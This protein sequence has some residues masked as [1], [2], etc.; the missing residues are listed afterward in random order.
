[1]SLLIQKRSLKCAVVLICIASCI[2]VATARAKKTVSYAADRGNTFTL[3][4]PTPFTV[5]KTIAVP[6]TLYSIDTS[7]TGDVVYLA[8]NLPLIISVPHGGMLEPAIPERKGSWGFIN[9][10]DDV[11]TID[12]ACDLVKAIMDRTNGKYPHV[13]INNI[14]R[15]KIDQNRGWGED[16]NP[17]GG[18]GGDAWKDFHERFI[19]SIAIPEVLKQYNTGLFIDLHGKPDKY[20][21]DIIVGYNLTSQD[22]SNSDKKLN[23]SK[24]S[25]ADKSTLR[26]LSKKLAAEIDFAELL[27]GATRNHESFGSLLQAGI[28]DINRNYKKKYSVIPRHEQKHPLVNLSG[29]YNIQVFCGVRHGATDNRYGYTDSRFISGFQ[30]EVCREIRI[31]NP[32]LRVDFA[33]K[34]ADAII[35]YTDRNLN[36]KM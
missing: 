24:R 9:K 20:G 15:T 6:G 8:G 13:V 34:L 14:S 35:A 2:F 11:A 31:K 22:L 26:F 3:P 36:I 5:G 4:A 10:Q 25:Y 21:A 27:R 7:A 17:T 18:R 29:G 32:T 30:L 12:L 1:M 28:N 23:S 19:G 16:R 33:R